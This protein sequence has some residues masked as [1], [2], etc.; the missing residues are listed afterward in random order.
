VILDDDP[1]LGD[2][3]QRARQG[4]ELDQGQGL[5]AADAVDRGGREGRVDRGLVVDRA[6]RVAQGLAALAKAAWTTARWCS[7]SGSARRARR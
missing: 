3:R 4:G 5:A 2:G 1:G 7:S 6:Q